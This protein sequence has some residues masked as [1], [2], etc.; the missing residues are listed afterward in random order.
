MG[1]RTGCAWG[2]YKSMGSVFSL[3]FGLTLSLWVICSLWFVKISQCH[4]MAC[5]S[6]FLAWSGWTFVLRARSFRN[7]LLW[8]TLSGWE[9]HDIWRGRCIGGRWNIIGWNRRRWSLMSRSCR[10]SGGGDFWG[11]WCGRR[12][13]GRVLGVCWWWGRIIASH[14]SLIGFCHQTCIFCHCTLTNYAPT[15]RSS[16]H[17]SP[18]PYDASTPVPPHSTFP[19]RIP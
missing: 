5:L 13:W 11:V 16:A 2:S 7:C 1:L 8:C 6:T 9:C 18:P 3:V 19:S 10:R 12:C 15:S 17:P 14:C 4:T